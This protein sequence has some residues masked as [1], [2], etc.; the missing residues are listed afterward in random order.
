MRHPVPL[1]GFIQVA[2]VVE[3]IEAALDGWCAVFGV[4][5]PP[6][7]VTEPAPDPEVTYRG[8]PASYGL[9]LAVIDCAER[10]FIIELHEPDQNPSTFREFLDR[11]GNGVHH[12][13]FRVGDARDA[14]VG[15]LVELGYPL[16]TVAADASWTIVDTEDQL[17][18]NLNVKP[19]P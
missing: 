2:L 11:H 9:K 10:G 8:E 15:D 1:D 14:V 13:G 6:V 4:P 18:V 17:G 3:D 7:H 5:R 12:L 19:R 16:R